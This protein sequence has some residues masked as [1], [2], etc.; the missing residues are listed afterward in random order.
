MTA[1]IRPGNDAD[2]AP[3]TAIPARPGPSPD[4][5]KSGRY[6]S[7]T[8]AA[9]LAVGLGTFGA[10]RW[11]LHG[12]ADRPGWLHLPFAAAGLVGVQRLRSLG[13]DDALAWVLVPVLGLTIAQAMLAAI[14]V[15]LTPDERWDARHNPGR[16]V[17]ATG[18]G[19]VLAAIAAL[20]LGGAVLMGTIAY[21]GQKF[22]EW[23][24]QA[25]TEPRDTLQANSR[26]RP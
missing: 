26:A 25:A 22:F 12:R 4:G 11:Y 21:A 9:W 14:V 10:H 16:P 2:L 7:K 6:R 18:W 20:M 8:V 15:A 24:L 5:W 23:Q 13:Q 19:P 3:A 1:T 17:H